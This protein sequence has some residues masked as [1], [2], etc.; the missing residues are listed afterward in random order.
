VDA[1]N[2]RQIVGDDLRR[3][4]RALDLLARPAVGY[5]D[6]MRVPSLGPPVDD[7][8]VAEQLEIQ[9]KYAGYI[10]RQRDEID[11]QRA[12]E[13]TELPSTL[14][15]EN[16]R[17]LSSEVREKL[18]RVRPATV[19]QASRIPGVTPAAVSLLLIH[20]KRRSG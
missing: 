9:A 3:E 20:L 10:D 16:V 12:Q 19:G 8:R 14:D 4:T 7:P 6:L 18:L 13:A 1:E 15:F 11:R 5:G 17:G 2:I